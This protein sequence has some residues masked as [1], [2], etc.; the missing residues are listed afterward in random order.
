M[1]HRNGFI[2]FIK[3]SGTVGLIL[4]AGTCQ[5]EPA[6]AILERIYN[7]PG[8]D[9]VATLRYT[10]NVQLPDRTVQRSWEWHPHSGRVVSAPDSADDRIEYNHYQLTENFKDL[11]ARFINDLY[12]LLFPYLILRDPHCEI[13]NPVEA[14]MPISGDTGRKI[15]VRFK[16]D[17]GYTPGDVYALF[18]NADGLIAEWIY[19][20]GGAVEPTRITTWEDTVPAGP[21]K[22]SLDHHGP[23]GRFRVWFS[24]V[25]IRLKHSTDWIEVSRRQ[26][27]DHQEE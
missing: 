1:F 7:R 15:T 14:T 10:F 16:A 2:S 20:R 6:R 3:F 9:E 19:Y 22:L 27:S 18:L 25:R 17:R 5:P 8:F 11:D 13:K 12:W 4:L 24:N 21:I 23:D 26:I